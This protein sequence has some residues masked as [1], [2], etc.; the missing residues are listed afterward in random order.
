MQFRLKFDEW[1]LNTSGP[2][3][4]VS[5]LWKLFQTEGKGTK[6]MKQEKL[7]IEMHD[8]KDILGL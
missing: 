4:T 2:L 1:K 6:G 8:F 5:Y 3:W 7:V